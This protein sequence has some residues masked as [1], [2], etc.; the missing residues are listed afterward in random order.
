MVL[1]VRTSLRDAERVK[2]LLRERELLL[3][4]YAPEKEARHLFLPVTREFE[5]DPPLTFVT[6]DLK[7]RPGKRDLRTLLE[8]KLT[9]EEEERLKTAFDI[10]GSIALVEVDEELRPKERLIAEAILAGNPSIRTVLKKLGGHEGE[11][12]LQRYA[13]LAGEDTRE[14]IV[15]EN[16]VRLK[17]DVE[18]VYYSVRSATERKRIASLVTPGERVLVMF[19][20]AAPYCCVIAKNTSASEVVGIELNERGHELGVENARLNKLTNV[21]LIHGDVRDAAPALHEQGIDFDRI[22]MPLPHTGH[23]FLDEAFLVARPGTVIHLYDFEAEG[24]FEQGAAKARAAAARNGRT[25]E[26]LGI[27]PSGQHSPRVY[28][29]CVDFKVNG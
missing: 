10:V 22:V 4:R 15:H 2:R 19:S 20:G 28:R 14:T 11:L 1:C 24:E 8:G 27:T 29:V 25:I 12:R 6:R 13:H 9:P 21:V 26:V 7:E 17:V 3:D 5:S 18:A 16:G 23:D